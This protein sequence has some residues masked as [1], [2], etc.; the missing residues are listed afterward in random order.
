MNFPQGGKLE[1]QQRAHSPHL[2][3]AQRKS[4]FAGLQGASIKTTTLFDD[5]QDRICKTLAHP[6]RV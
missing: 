5:P 1:L 3:G 2:V 4:R 6:I